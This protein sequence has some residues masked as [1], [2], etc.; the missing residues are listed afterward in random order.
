MSKKVVLIILDSAG[1][2]AL[3]DA[4]LYGDEGSNT[5]GN[6]AKKIGGLH[7]PNLA[8]LGLGNISPI[9]GVPPQDKPFGAYGKMREKSP[10]KDTT[11]G[12][13]EIAGIILDQPFPT[14]PHGFPPEVIDKFEKSIGKKII[15]NVAASGTEII[16]QLGEKH[17]KTA[18]P[19]VYT[20]ADSVFQIAAHEKVIPLEEL[21]RFCEIARKLLTG[22]HAVGRVIARPFNGSCGKFYRTSGRHDY[23][24]LPPKDTMLDLIKKNG[25]HVIGIGKINDIYAGRGITK[26]VKTKNNM[27]GIKST[28]QAMDLCQRGLVFTNLVDFDML[29]GHRNDPLGYARALE[30]FDQKVPDIINK[31]NEKDLLILT[32]DHG[33]DPTTKS[34]DHSREY[35]PLIMYG[36]P[37]KK[38]VYLGVRGTF[39]DVGATVT[40]YLGVGKLETGTSMLPLILD[41]TS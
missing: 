38:P 27:E 28:L 6:I 9:L 40:S 7:L 13:W 3:P 36:K 39:A 8:R 35:V 29:Y 1:V 26:A 4:K 17:L 19:I 10:G 24:L 31:L 41:Q 11:T 21:Y 37:I 22:K 23:S 32:A 2:G 5:L 15:G 34:T 33:T 14:Y 16:K 18:Y 12:H 20:S 25:Q 30:E